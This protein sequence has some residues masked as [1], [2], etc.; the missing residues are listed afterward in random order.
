M[1]ISRSEVES[2]VLCGAEGPEEVGHK[3]GSTIR[4]Y[5]AWDTILGEDVENEEL[6]KLL[7][8]DG[9]VSWDEE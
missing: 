9:M 8:H 1:V 3:W 4:G 5:M 7:R 2:H 6:Y